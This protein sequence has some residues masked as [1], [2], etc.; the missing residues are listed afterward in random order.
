MADPA[1]LAR[2]TNPQSPDPHHPSDGRPAIPPAQP[3]AD[4]PA[5][6]AG[7][8]S[9]GP[10]GRSADRGGPRRRVR[11]GSADAT[12]AVVPHLL[13][14]HPAESLVV[15]GVGGPHSRIRLAFRYDLPDPPEEGLAADIAAHAT[16]VLAR[17]HLT[18]A[19]AIGYGSGRQVTPVADVLIPALREAGIQVQ[20]VLR[21]Q[22]GRY[23]SYLCADPAC[24]PP[25]GVPFD[26]AGHPASAALAE[27]GL[28]VHGNR[29]ELAATLAPTVD[30]AKSMSA[31]VGRA[32]DRATRLVTD[33]FADSRYGDVFQLVADA[34]RRSVRLAVTR[35][36]RGG[37]LTDNHDELAWLGVVL[38]DMRVRD[39]AWARM[40]P[41]FNADHQ[42]LWVDL[43]RH[44]PSEYV[45]APAALLAFTAW[46]AGEGALASLAIERALAADPDYSM[47]QLIADALHAG[48]PP[49]AA[50]LPMTP[51][52][53]A[54]SYANLR[55]A[56]GHRAKTAQARKAGPRRTPRRDSRGGPGP[57]ANGGTGSTGTTGT[58]RTGTTGTGGAGN[59]GPRSTGTTGT[60]RAGNGGPKRSGRAGT[61]PGQ[62]RR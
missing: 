17:Q 45:P 5:D 60:G 57:S 18:L 50:R 52:Q 33:A 4:R 58:R 49:S 1:N 34:G 10:A 6:K 14:F 54:A 19:I 8:S 62:L 38:T 43:V 15:L 32:Q 40:D 47:A 28:T 29:A 56:G 12:L 7:R 21:V 23:W 48:L 35:Y 31:A 39:D 3:S 41:E 25:D 46:Q 20:D 36:R 44:L 9:D 42:R 55:S 59:G 11:I 30:C 61:G 53:V 2:M 24:C 13:G 16:T 37:Q 51:K 22:D 27:A 26:P